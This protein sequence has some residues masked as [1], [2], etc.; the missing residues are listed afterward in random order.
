MVDGGGY[1]RI[2]RVGEVFVLLHEGV[3]KDIIGAAMAVLNALKP[4]LDEKL[5][6]NALVLELKASGHAAEQQCRFPVQYRGALIGTLVP[7]LIVDGLVIVD[8]K[9]VAAFNDAHLAQMTG[10]LAITGLQVGLLINFKDAKLTWKRVVREQAGAP[11]PS[12]APSA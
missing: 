1:P 3:T 8:A 2:M 12:S 9:V 5:Y 11:T 4:G 7:D 10:Y 6:E